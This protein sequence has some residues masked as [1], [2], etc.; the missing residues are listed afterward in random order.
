MV[1]FLLLD[2]HIVSADLAT[3]VQELIGNIV[4]GL[5]WVGGK[6]LVV[7]INL[8]IWVAQYNG[9][10]NS[11][12]VSTGWTILRDVCNMFFILILLVIAFAT[13][14]NIESYGMKKLLKDFVLA[15]IL[16]NFS[17]L[18]CGVIIDFAQVIMLTFVN[19]FRDIG[20]GNL[21][22]MLGITKLL[23]QATGACSG[24]ASLLGVMGTYI[25]ALL[26]VIV[27]IVV[28]LAILFMLIM[29]IVMIWMY[30]VLSPLAYLLSVLPDTKK[31]AGMWWSQF[32]EAV[33]SGPI[34]A[35]FIWLS[36]ASAT[37]GSKGQDIIGI[38]QGSAT[39]NESNYLKAINES[40]VGVSDAGTADSMLKFL[41]SIGLLLGGLMITKQAGGMVGGIAGGAL[42]KLQGWGG[43]LGKKLTAMPG[44]VAKSSLKT[45]GKA[46]AA[47]GKALGRGVL[48]GGGRA[49]DSFGGAMGGKL[50]AK[51]QGAGQF[52]R[53]WGEDLTKKRNTAKEKKKQ[54]V[55]EKLG[56]GEKGQKGLQDWA[57][58]SPVIGGT[59]AALATG[60]VGTAASNLLFKQPINWLGKKG[61]QIAFNR[62][63]KKVP[64]NTQ[65]VVDTTAQ[66]RDE[67]LN[68]M[69]NPF[70]KKR[71]AL[72]DIDTR[73]ENEK[74]SI[75][76][77]WEAEKREAQ[78]S[79]KPQAEI[80]K[81]DQS[82][83]DRLAKTNERYQKLREDA[84]KDYESTA[85]NEEKAE[86]R[87]Y[88]PDLDRAENIHASA[89][90]NHQRAQAIA[91]YGDK[92]K[93]VKAE[94][95]RHEA[96]MDDL[97]KQR[98]TEVQEVR[99]K[100][101]KSSPAVAQ[102]LIDGVHQRYNQKEAD[103][104]AEHNKNIGDINAKYQLGDDKN[105][106]LGLVNSVIRGVGGA[107]QKYNPNK[108]VEGA[109]KGGLKEYSDAKNIM[110][111]LANQESMAGFQEKSFSSAE[112]NSGVN[113]KLF[114]G[115]AS[116][117]EEAKKSL[118]GFIKAL[119]DTQEKIKT[120]K[121]GKDSHEIKV[122]HAI[123]RG[124]G[125]YLSDKPGDRAAFNTVISE[126]E[127]I[128]SNDKQG[129]MKIDE[130]IKKNS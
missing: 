116:G 123:K 57:K 29:R 99:D 25:L 18:I 101:W 128:D 33:A 15:A 66:M 95:K 86:D 109:I 106:Q 44:A 5:V 38:Q 105:I 80:D 97:K 4:S 60:S 34:L 73:Q 43:T 19:G 55:L 114:E 31:Y 107:M 69:S 96:V 85:S 10:I 52:A 74:N 59:A 64:K 93:E 53:G 112:G 124:L 77:D 58:K 102:Q 62:Q 130:F 127:K 113:N 54:K 47:S 16:I 126:L 8:V 84:E 30:V 9:F 36:F 79:H 90:L 92:K 104:Q 56:I 89:Q 65:K 41:I 75:H 70:R 49:L 20:G 35:F 39:T 21:A 7:L 67:V 11:Q 12:A 17:K 111:A 50:G 120:G 88:Q 121:V 125:N 78:E 28:I 14:L 100:Y 129:R 82:Y 48:K 108:L 103:K 46:G 27:G 98:A 6:I 45:V 87:G 23:S 81:I 119:Q 24:N 40:C 71:Q 110:N 76:K 117:T 2:P 1:V 63:R 51:V 3:S 22:D 122:V 42:G 26:Y 13:T 68:K 32:A 91:K 72:K 83:K 115:L 118:D 61:E 94:D 37:V